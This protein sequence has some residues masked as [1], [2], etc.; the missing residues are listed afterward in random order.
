MTKFRDENYS[1]YPK[2]GSGRGFE[3]KK[4]IYE[5]RKHIDTSGMVETPH[6]FVSAYSM[7]FQG[8]YS[9]SRVE[10]IKDGRLYVRWFDKYLTQRGLVTKAK[11]FANEL[12]A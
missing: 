11:Q 10:M 12:Y 1:I 3:T 5:G 9:Q 6:G 2:T 8:S 7:Y 4:E